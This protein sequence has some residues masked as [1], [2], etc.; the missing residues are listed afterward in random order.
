MKQ[1]ARLDAAVPQWLETAKVWYEATRDVLKPSTRVG[2][3]IGALKGSQEA[4]DHEGQENNTTAFSNA[5]H[6]S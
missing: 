4:Y 3:P 1:P 6:Q 2:P 5:S